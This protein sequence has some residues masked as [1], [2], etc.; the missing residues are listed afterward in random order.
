MRASHGC[1]RVAQCSAAAIC[2]LPAA[3][4]FPLSSLFP[5]RRSL[6]LNALRRRDILRSLIH[7]LFAALCTPLCH[8]SA[9]YSSMFLHEIFALSQSLL[10]IA[11]L[12]PA[13]ELISLPINLCVES[14]EKERS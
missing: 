8:P 2:Y 13:S 5:C 11:L 14:G 3:L 6:P 12:S 10:L 4:L 9:L 7:V 1:V